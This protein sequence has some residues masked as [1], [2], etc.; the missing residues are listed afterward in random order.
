VTVRW[1]EGLDTLRLKKLKITPPPRNAYSQMWN[2]T[3]DAEFTGLHI[4]L[5][6]LLGEKLWDD[7]YMCCDN[8]FKVQI[9]ASALCTDDHGFYGPVQVFVSAL[10]PFDWKHHSAWQD[11]YGDTIRVKADYGVSESV[12]ENVRKQFKNV[13]NQF[14]LKHPDGRYT[15]PLDAM[16]VI[17]Q[18]V[19]KYNS[20]TKCPHIAS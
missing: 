4:W 8:P 18:N 7:D 17:L 15:N 19:V 11:N 12:Q 14:R 10:D 13:V 2:L 5:K 20:G 16:A 6:V 9:R 3:L 1:A